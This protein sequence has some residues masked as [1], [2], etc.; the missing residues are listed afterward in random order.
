MGHALTLNR[1]ITVCQ[2]LLTMR[3]QASRCVRLGMFTAYRGASVKNDD[4]RAREWRLLLAQALDDA[5]MSRAE[6]G[7][8]LGR[9]S[10][11]VSQW[12]NDGN[13]YGPPEP[14]VVFAIE[15]VLG[16]RGMLASVLGY[17]RADV[18]PTVESA[19]EADPELMP[20]QKQTLLLQVESSRRAARDQRTRRRQPPA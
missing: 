9:T 3:L 6:L 5:G 11:Q 4:P 7:R 17:V 20:V 10:A 19:I 18:T 1:M 15:D 14:D 8:H 16:C 13:R 2:A 12:V